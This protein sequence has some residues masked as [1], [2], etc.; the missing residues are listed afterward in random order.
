MSATE[1]ATKISDDRNNL[2]GIPYSKLDCQAF[3][4]Y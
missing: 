3:V 2:I 4:E 1:W